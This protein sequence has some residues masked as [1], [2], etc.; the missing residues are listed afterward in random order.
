[1]SIDLHIAGP[2]GLGGGG[3]GGV[4]TL[5][6]VTDLGN[7]TTNIVKSTAGFYVNNG[8]DEFRINPAS[9]D[10]LH[11]GAF[12]GGIHYSRDTTPVPGALFQ[13][14]WASADGVQQVSGNGLYLPARKITG[15]YTV[16]RQDWVIL[17]DT[18]A[19]GFDILLPTAAATP[20][21]IAPGFSC[22]IKNIGG[23]VNIANVKPDNAAFTIE[24]T[25][26]I[27]LTGNAA[28][29]QSIWVTQDNNRNWWIVSSYGL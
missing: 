22:C 23:N 19:G 25:A 1:M 28:V 20:G 15:N 26:N 10:I 3:G 21:S 16:T 6:Q 9:L 14:R 7:N 29:M 27:P 18:S 17:C 4:G 2:I 24:T 8:V 5:Q 13:Q 11:L 12:G